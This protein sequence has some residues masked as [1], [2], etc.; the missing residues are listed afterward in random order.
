MNMKKLIYSTLLVVLFFGIPA[1][2]KDFLEL[3]PQTGLME[4]NFYKTENDAFL[5]M[6]AVYDALSVQNWQYVPIMSD[7]F[8]DDAFGGGADAGDMRQWHEIEQN[9]LTPENSA[10]EALWSRCYSG[11]YRA[12]LYLQKQDGIAWTNEANKKQME[13]EV[14]FLR[15]Y[16]YW[17]LVRHYGSVPVLTAM[18]PNTEDY[19]TVPQDAPEVAFKQ[20]ANDLL[21]A[22]ENCKTTTTAS[23]KGRATKY[24]AEALLARVYMFY[25]D[26]AKPVWGLTGELTNGTVTV[27]ANYVRTALNDIITNGGFTLVPNYADIFSYTNENNSE[28]IFEWQYSEKAKSDDWGGWGI[29]GN[30][31]VV[32]YGPRNPKGASPHAEVEGWSFS[33]ITWSAYNEFEAGDPRRDASIFNANTELTSYTKA[34]QNT[35]YFNRK[36]MGVKAFE[37]TAGSTPH[38]WRINYKDIRYAEVLLMAAE[39]NLTTDAVK[40]LNYLN[41]VRTRAMGTGAALTVIDKAAIIHESRVEFVGEGHRKWDLL[42]MGLD[43]TETK[44]K[45][46]FDATTVPAVVPNPDDFTM[47]AFNKN[48]WGLFP[49][50]GKEIRNMNAGLLKQYAPAYK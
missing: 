31:S 4:D 15:A 3:E 21:F 34:F 14:R 17:D 19:K 29:N 32:F 25:T 48:N 8:S 36:Y 13:G 27:D 11:I 6:T 38:N 26:F 41:Q 33:T 10:A 2:T 22:I 7:I 46:S 28:S 35:G 43:Y 18:L 44:V 37:G 23:E 30:F 12:N 5:A 20:V 16:F 45:E 24:A 40:A 42:R 50:P 49:I 39:M 47:R 1:C 9:V